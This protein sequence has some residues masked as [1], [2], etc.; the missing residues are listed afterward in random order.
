MIESVNLQPTVKVSQRQLLPL[1]LLGLLLVALL[2]IGQWLWL[3]H[4][5][6]APEPQTVLP[7]ERMPLLDSLLRQKT[8]VVSL[9][10]SAFTMLLAVLAAVSPLTWWARLLGLFRKAPAAQYMNAALWN[11]EPQTAEEWVA[12]Q[13]AL[14]GVPPTGVATE[15]GAAAHPGQVPG[16]PLVSGQPLPGQQPGTPPA[17]GQP[18]TLPAGQQ[19]PAQQPT[20]PGQPLPGQQPGMPPASDQPGTLPA[21]QQPPPAQQPGTPGQ[22]PA[23]GAPP[24]PG[25]QPLP[26]GQQPPAQQPGAPQPPGQP[27]PAAPPPQQGLQQLLA[28]EEKMDIKELTDI[29]DILSSFKENDDVPAQLLALSQSLG[30]VDI[31]ALVAHSRRVVTRLTAA[32][33]VAQQIRKKGERKTPV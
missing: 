21:G 33:S 22:A 13:A 10:A 9:L 7:S 16:V 31:D 18:S 25:Q 24:A 28:T 15:P 2:L 30:E 17:P 14:L 23:P 5:L 19:P 20:A 11:Q 4:T 12:A 26:A 3:T 1:I 32:N 6:S 27:A 8:I 29:G